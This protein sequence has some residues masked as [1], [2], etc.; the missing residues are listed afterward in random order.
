MPMP[1]QRPAGEPSG[2]ED[3]FGDLGRKVLGGAPL[4]QVLHQVADLTTRALPDAIDVSVTVLDVSPGGQ[5]R[6]GR[7]RS[8]AFAG[9]LAAVLDERQY[10]A[11]LGPCLDAAA[12]GDTIRVVAEGYDERYTEF[13]AACRVLGVAESLSIGLSG[14]EHTAAASLNIYGLP[15]TQDEVEL[16]TAFAGHAAVALANANL[17][18]AM[19]ELAHT[20]RRARESRAVLDQA[21]GIIMARRNRSADQAFEWLRQESRDRKVGLH[22]LAQRIV[23]ARGA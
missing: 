3:V 11:G 18:H 8:I 19:A 12:S 21:K 22:D 14:H 9:T 5:P 20:L 6:S 16:A 4:N 15:F 7:A 17:Q 10:E 2:S 23:D 1:H 13:A